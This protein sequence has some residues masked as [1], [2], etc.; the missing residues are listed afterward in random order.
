MTRSI[1]AVAALLLCLPALGA[2]CK[3]RE[4][5]AVQ[6]VGGQTVQVALEPAIA[7]QEVTY[8]SSTQSAAFNDLT[9]F[10]LIVC[11]A[12]A[13]FNFGSNPTADAADVYLPADTLY[14]TG[15]TVGTDLKVAFYD[16]ST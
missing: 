16:G 6:N 9:T 7:D 4:F 15:V 1:G 3:I 14:A 8:T 10:I 11:D 2:E 13:H 12:T 5:T